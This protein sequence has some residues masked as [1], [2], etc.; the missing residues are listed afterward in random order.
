M[1]ICLCKGLTESDLLSAADAG[2]TGSQALVDHFGWEDK[3]C[4][5]RCARNIKE[6]AEFSAEPCPLMSLCR[7]R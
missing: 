4:C 1:Y 2:H 3:D 5:G 6:I 7:S